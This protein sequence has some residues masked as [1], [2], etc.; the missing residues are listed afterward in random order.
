MG[1]ENFLVSEIRKTPTAKCFQA[2][3]WSERD[4]FPEKPAAFTAKREK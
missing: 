2:I 3:S 4:T 1:K